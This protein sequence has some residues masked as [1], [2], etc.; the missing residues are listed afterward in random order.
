MRVLVTGGAGYV[1]SVSV[2]RLVEAGHDVTVLDDLSTGHRTA[3]IDGAR[4]VGRLVRGRSAV[5]AA[6]RGV[7]DRGG[8][9]L[10]GPLAGRPNR[11]PTRRSTTA[12]TWPAGSPCSRR[13]GPPASA[14]SSSRRRRRSTASRRRPR[15]AR[16]SRSRRSTRTARRSGPS[17]APCGWYGPAYGLRS[18]SLRY[19]NVAGASERN[20]ERHDPETHL[21]PNVLDAV[22][23]GRPLTIFGTDYPT[24]DGTNIRDYIH[25]AD[26]ADAHLAALEATDAG[27]P[28]DGRP[29]RAR[30]R[31]RAVA[32]SPSTSAARPASRS[33]R[34]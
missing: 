33:A 29:R 31:R 7:G 26:L 15:S 5:C 34:W 22:E 17:R 1:G 18:V 32:P 13:S 30:R 20:G 2:E 21:I 9:P 27:R 11:S 19:F 6:A 3:A 4:L 14:G 16:M 24:P 28:A 23:S 10:R 8:P 12:T 25:V